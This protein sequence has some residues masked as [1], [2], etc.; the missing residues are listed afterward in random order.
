VEYSRGHY[1]SAFGYFTQCIELARQHGY[2]RVIASNLPLRAEI[3]YRE[4]DFASAEQD[5]REAVELAQKTGNLRAELMAL[6]VR[7]YLH[8]KIGDPDTAMKWMKRSL[9][10]CHLLGSKNMQGMCLSITAGIAFDQGDRSAAVRFA[11][12][13]VEILREAD[14]GMVFYGPN[15]LGVLVLATEDIELRRNAMHE[16]EALLTDFS[17]SHNYLGFYEMA[18]EVCIQMAAW[19]EAERYAQ[20]LE[21]YMRNE[22]MPHSDFLIARGRA[23]TSHGRGNQDQAT[24]HELQRLYDEANKLGLKVSMPALEAALTST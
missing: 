12:Q 10:I 13:S 5:A 1:K 2:G 14:S 9:D 22:P 23:L 21:K 18:M 15:T 3:H 24:M 19:D 16:A 17:T 7:S 8:S 11:Q 6:S 4:L 20:A